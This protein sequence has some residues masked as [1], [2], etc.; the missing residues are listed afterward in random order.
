MNI[1]VWQAL[2][3]FAAISVVWTFFKKLECKPLEF[4]YAL[5]TIF[6]ALLP[7]LVPAGGIVLLMLATSTIEV[8]PQSYI[9]TKQMLKEFPELEK[10]FLAIYQD[11][12]MTISEYVDLQSKHQDLKNAKIS[13]AANLEWEET[14][15]FLDEKFLLSEKVK[16]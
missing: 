1:P 15:N 7:L 13:E 8:C 14:R 3:L 5:G 2:I 6:C 4:L 10:P 16:P 11:G 12:K 9:N